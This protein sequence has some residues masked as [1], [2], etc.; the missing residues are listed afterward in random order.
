MQELQD[1]LCTQTLL[2]T[3]RGET[4]AI[5]P[6]TYVLEAST[7]RGIAAARALSHTEG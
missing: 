7:D 5:S 4:N 1:K 2:N 3:S 6:A